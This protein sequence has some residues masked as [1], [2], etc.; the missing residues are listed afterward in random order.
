MSINHIVILPTAASLSPPL[1]A[2]GNLDA[3]LEP[4]SWGGSHVQSG[5]PYAEVA[6][7]ASHRC[8]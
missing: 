8:L 5:Y 6:F 2:L 3:Y 4:P 1:P 7:Q